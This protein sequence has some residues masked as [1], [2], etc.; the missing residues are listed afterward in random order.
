[1]CQV[2]EHAAKRMK[3]R[4]GS[5]K[6]SVQKTAQT[7]LER[8]ITHAETAG[9]LKRYLDHLYLL[10][11]KANNMRIWGDKVFIFRGESLITVLNLPQKYMGTCVKIQERKKANASS[12]TPVVVPEIG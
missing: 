4:C 2:N 7:A 5:N 1:M 9:S 6:A 8:G 3:E 10:H 11:R 12:E